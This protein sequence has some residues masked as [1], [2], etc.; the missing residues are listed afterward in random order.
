MDRIPA[1]LLIHRAAQSRKGRTD[2]GS[3]G[4]TESYVSVATGI[5]CRLA[6]IG[7]PG[8][9][10]RAA[11]QFGDVSSKVIGGPS[12]D[13]RRGDRLSIVTNT[14]TVVV[15]VAGFTDPSEAHVY[16]TAYVREDPRQGTP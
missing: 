7:S 2:S 16:R 8:E 3:G 13:I 11:Q 12:W 15:E 1:R 5:P 6:A 9:F 10:E 14:R 4:F